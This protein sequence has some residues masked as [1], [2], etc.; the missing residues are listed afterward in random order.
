VDATRAGFTGHH[1]TPLVAAL[2]V[3]AGVA[4]ALT[5]TAVAL[6]GRAGGA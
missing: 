4:S 2:L 6:V 1:E 3:A 5:A